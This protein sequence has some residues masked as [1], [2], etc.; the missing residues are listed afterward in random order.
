[1]G[2][3][4]A[5]MP[6]NLEVVIFSRC[7]NIKGEPQ[8]FGSS[9]AQGH[10][11]FSL[12]VIWWRALANPNGIPNLKSLASAVAEML[13]G[14]PKIL[15]SSTSLLPRPIFLGGI[16]WWALAKP[17]YQPILKSL[18]SVIA[19]PLKEKH[20]FWGTPLAQGHAHF[21]FCVQF[22]DGPWKIQTAHQIV[23]R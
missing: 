22:Y 13:K 1:M 20:K 6:A 3:G 4:K 12:G 18:S 10:A 7:R 11:H 16:L 17:T 23:S 9:L 2:L 21:F 14:N 8:F 15:G 5:Q 19:A